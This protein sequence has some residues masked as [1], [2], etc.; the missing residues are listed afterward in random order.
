[1]FFTC[2]RRSLGWK[3]EGLTKLLKEGNLESKGIFL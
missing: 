3:S 1:P 2:N